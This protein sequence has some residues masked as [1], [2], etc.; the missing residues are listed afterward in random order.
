MWYVPVYLNCIKLRL[1]SQLNYIAQHAQAR[2]FRMIYG[3]PDVSDLSFGL[4]S[5]G[6]GHCSQE[7]SQDFRKEI[8]DLEF[9]T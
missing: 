8:F 4:L 1:K 5:L 9:R 6:R 3:T 7:P 2:V